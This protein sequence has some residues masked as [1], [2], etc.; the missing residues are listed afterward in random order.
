MFSLQQDLFVSIGYAFA[1]VFLAFLAMCFLSVL[2]R[3]VK[4]IRGGTKKQL[5]QKD[6]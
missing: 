6:N 2:V 5:T 1:V 3:R 4:K